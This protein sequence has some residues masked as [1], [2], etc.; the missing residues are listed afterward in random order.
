M[1]MAVADFDGDSQW[2]LYAT[3]EGLSPFLLGYDNLL[4]ALP[5]DGI[6]QYASLPQ[7]KSAERPRIVRQWL[8]P[9]HSMLHYKDGVLR[10][11]SDWTLESPHLLAGDLFT[12]SDGRYEYWNPASHLERLPWAWAAVALD[13]DADG[14][15]DVAFNGNACAAPM[16][17]VGDEYNG[18]GPGGLLINAEGEGFIDKIWE[19][20]IANVD[21]DGLYQ[22]GRGLAVGDLN[23]DGYPDLVF[24]NRSYNP[25][26]TNPLEQ[27]TGTP[28]VW[29][30]TPRDNNW[31]QIDLEGT[32]SNR[33]GI[34]SKVTVSTPDRNLTQWFRAGGTLASSNESLLH[35]GLGAADTVD[36]TVRFPSGE[37]IERTAVSANQRILISEGE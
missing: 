20:G 35:F 33:D 25:S 14:W 32:I 23:N 4:Y 10:V 24:A 22:D 3:N 21:E 5:N 34:G 26:D 31:L 30:S 18:A 11:N 15:P 17:I 12:D 29:L 28:Q 37:I 7:L 16:A 19:A 9:F 1:G 36:I 13:V 6:A 27:R 8:N 2:D